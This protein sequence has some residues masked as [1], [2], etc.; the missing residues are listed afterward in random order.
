MKKEWGSTEWLF[1]ILALTWAA[2]LV[3]ASKECQAKCYPNDS[4][5]TQEL[6]CICVDPGHGFYPPK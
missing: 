3:L 1:F 4:Q 2:I 6:G 5:I